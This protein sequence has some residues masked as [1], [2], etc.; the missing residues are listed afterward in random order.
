MDRVMANSV[1]TRAFCLTTGTA[2]S[3]IHFFPSAG[4]TAGHYPVVC[5]VTVFGKGIERRSVQ[6]DGGRLNQ[7]DGIRLE[8]AFPALVNETSGICGIEV[9][10]SSPQ[11]RINLLSSR[12]VVEV[13]SPHYTLSYG[14]ARFSIA[15]E[16]PA[17]SDASAVEARLRPQPIGVSM[18]DDKCTPSLVIVNPTKDLARPEFRHIVRGE[19]A[20]LHLGTVAPESVVEFPLED[21][22]TKSGVRRQTLWGESIIEKMWSEASALDASV[23]CYLLLRDPETRQPFSVCAI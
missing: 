2:R 17:E 5:E 7:P 14:A 9:G 20:P 6:L 21:T 13:V 16:Q 19:E 23:E 4:T 11:G 15:G 18:Y 1:V 10:L 8:D 3:R 12:L 22:L